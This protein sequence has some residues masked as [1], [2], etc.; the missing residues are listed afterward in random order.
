MWELCSAAVKFIV[1]YVVQ[2]KHVM[3]EIVRS[4]WWMDKC[5]SIILAQ[6]IPA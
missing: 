6:T 5:P 4:K 2:V 1:K 3:L